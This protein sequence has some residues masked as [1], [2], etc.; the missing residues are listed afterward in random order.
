MPD[1]MIVEA[2]LVLT[3][4][5]V[6]VDRGPSFL[7]AAD[8]LGIS[9]FRPWRGDPWPRGVQEDD[10]FRFDWRPARVRHDAETEEL[11]AA[12]VAVTRPDHVE[13]RRTGR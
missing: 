4:L 13:V 5:W 7:H 2:V 9:L 8:E 12:G 10:D 11:V 1:P 6:I 3:L